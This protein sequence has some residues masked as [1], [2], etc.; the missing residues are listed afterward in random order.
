VSQ[1]LLRFVRGRSQPELIA[2]I[3]RV[4]FPDATTA[5]DLTP[6]DR[7]GFWSETAPTH[8]KVHVSFDDFRQLEL[9]DG[10]F[11]VSFFDPPHLPD[12]GPRSVMRLRFGTLAYRDWEPAVRDGARE[13]FRVGRLGCVIKVCDL[14][15]RQRF[16]DMRGWIT[17]DLGTPYDVVHFVRP[18]PITSPKWTEPQ[19]SARSNGATFLIYRHGDQRHVRRAASE[20]RQP[21]LEAHR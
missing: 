20:Y 7:F 2:D 4:F 1:A 17:E 19:L 21:H 13:A 18:Q 11:D 6:S 14:V 16:H 8:L 10:A 9:Q 15:N 5:V 3:A 12:A